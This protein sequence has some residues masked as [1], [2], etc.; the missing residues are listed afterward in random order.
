[1]AIHEN[2]PSNGHARPSRKGLFFR[3]GRIES[4]ASPHTQS[5]FVEPSFPANGNNAPIAERCGV[6]DDIGIKSDEPRA[7]PHFGRIEGNT[8]PCLSRNGYRT[9]LRFDEV[10]NNGT[11]SNSLSNCQDAHIQV[12]A[13]A[14]FTIVHLA[15]QFQPLRGARRFRTCKLSS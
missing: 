14:G 2:P 7:G 8:H 13:V 4:G 3:P 11:D 5:A 9:E 10:A 12:K 15:G 1:M 6:S